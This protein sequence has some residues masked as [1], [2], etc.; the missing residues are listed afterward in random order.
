MTYIA[1][2]LLVI[3]GIIL[4]LMNILIYYTEVGILLYASYSSTVR[5][6]GSP[7]PVSWLQP[8]IVIDNF[9]HDRESLAKVIVFPF[10]I[11]AVG[12]IAYGASIYAIAVSNVPDFP[13]STAN[14]ITVYALWH[15]GGPHLRLCRYWNPAYRSTRY[16]TALKTLECNRTYMTTRDL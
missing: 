14:A 1:G 9:F 12:L 15:C 8:G 7:L 10:F 13:Y 4:G 2:I 5:C 6:S 3:I 11:G 16:L